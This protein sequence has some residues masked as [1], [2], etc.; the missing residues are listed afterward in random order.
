M[1]GRVVEGGSL[2]RDSPVRPIPRN[3][4]IP[5]VRR[6]AKLLQLPLVRPKGVTG[7]TAINRSWDGV[8]GTDGAT[9]PARKSDL[10]LAGMPLTVFGC[11][12]FW[13]LKLDRSAFPKDKAELLPLADVM[14]V[15]VACLMVIVVGLKCWRG[16]PLRF[17]I[18]S[19]VQRV[20]MFLLGVMWLALGA[21]LGI[22]LPFIGLGFVVGLGF[23]SLGA[24]LAIEGAVRS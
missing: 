1:G 6:E 23:V 18:R 2:E 5:A 10:L 14:V 3:T 12:A 19:A 13:F 4:G 20:A 16:W 17:P 9:R 21:A 8:M 7:N 11:V 15:I 24:W 22:V